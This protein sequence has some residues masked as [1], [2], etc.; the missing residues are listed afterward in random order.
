MREEQVL[1]AG[2]QLIEAGRKLTD[3][4]GY[5]GPKDV[6]DLNAELDDVGKAIVAA[7]EALTRAIG[8][9]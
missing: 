6:K 8:E 5:R 7:G 1:E 4:S 3:L 2:R 9:G